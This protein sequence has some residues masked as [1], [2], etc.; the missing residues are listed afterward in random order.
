MIK[1]VDLNLQ[2]ETIDANIDHNQGAVHTPDP[3]DP[4]VQRT[5]DHHAGGENLHLAPQ[6]DG[7]D[8]GPDPMVGAGILSIQT[9][10]PP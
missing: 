6:T 5:G 4:G 2:E 1:E 3:K 8:P 7:Q 10:T 9:V